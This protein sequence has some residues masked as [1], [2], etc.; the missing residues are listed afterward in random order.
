MIKK[1]DHLG[2]FVRD[3]EA[4]CRIYTE[5]FGLPRRDASVKGPNGRTIRVAFLQV[6][7]TSIE[8]LEWPERVDQWG[9][10]INHIAFEVDD[11][12]QHLADLVTAGVPV[13]DETPRRGAEADKIAFLRR[14]AAD[15]VRIELCQ[16]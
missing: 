1:I 13:E 11:I 4:A 12:E 9:E 8:L 14:E 6:G 15:G 2:I 10:G 3:L 7:E 16:M 5:Q